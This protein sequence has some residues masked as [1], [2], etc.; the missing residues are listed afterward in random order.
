MNATSLGFRQGGTRPVLPSL[1][2]IQAA[3]GAK[4]AKPLNNLLGF[5]LQVQ[6]GKQWAQK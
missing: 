5:Y 1:V 6:G 4:N 3:S 2:I